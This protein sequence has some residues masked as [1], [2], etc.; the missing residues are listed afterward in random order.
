M[1]IEF[2]RDPNFWGAIKKVAI[3][4]NPAL[5]VRLR[6]LKDRLVGPLQDRMMS[7]YVSPKEVDGIAFSMW[8]TNRGERWTVDG[9]GFEEEFICR[10]INC[11]NPGDTV[12]DVGAANGTHTLPAAIKT[13]ENGLV[14]S[15]EPEPGL[16]RGIR[17]NLALNAIT[18]V[19]VM[20]TALW[21]KDGFLMLHTSGRG[22]QAPQVCLIGGLPFMRFTRHREIQARGIDSLIRSCEVRPPDVMKIDVEGAGQVVL[23][24]LGDIRPRHIL[25]E[26]HPL[27]G[28]NRDE[29][30][31]FL[32]GRG[33]GIIWECP[34]GGEKHIHFQLN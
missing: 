12:F 16:A 18:N 19:R 2:N 25:M 20:E 3:T 5:Y 7:P 9:G 10:M 15:F 23:E 17:E 8:V 14:Y 11:I 32:R 22:G 21:K 13:G 6:R 31:E 4:Y 29:I 26:V 30:V 24:G 34:R 28:E 27:F 1:S 33:Y